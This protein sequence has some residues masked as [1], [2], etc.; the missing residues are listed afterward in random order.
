MAK[1]KSKSQKSLLKRLKAAFA[2]MEVCEKVN[3]SG[4]YRLKNKK[5]EVPLRSY[6]IQL[7][8]GQNVDAPLHLYPEWLINDD[9]E[10]ETSDHY[11]LFDPQRYFSEI[12]G[13]CR[14]DDGDKITLGDRHNSECDFVDCGDCDRGCRLSIRN[15]EGHLTFKDHNS[16]EGA[17]ISPLVDEKKINKLIKW[18]RGKLNRLKDIYGGPIKPLSDGDALKLIEQVNELQLEENSRP[19]NRK[20]LPG[21]VVKL[22]KGVTPIIVG[23]LHTKLDNLLVILSQN[24]FLESLEDGSAALI[25]L[26]DAVHSEEAGQYDKMKSSML[27]MDFIFKLKIRFPE[28][29]FYIRGNHDSFS[30]EIGKQGVPQGLL[31]EKTLL[32]QRGKAYHKAMQRL[33]DL[34][35]YVVHSKYFAACHAAPPT[36]SPD[37]EKLINITDHPDLIEE[38]YNNRLEKPNRPS[39]YNKRDIK[40]FRKCLGL[41]SDTPVIVGHTPLSLDETLWE[42]VNNI[43]NHYVVYGAGD[44]WIG[45]ITQVRGEI[46]PLRYPTEP[47][48]GY[49]DTLD[50]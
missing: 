2:G 30:E 26:G 5:I 9:G 32:K 50:D 44:E 18:R 29:V 1:S 15:E 16:T 40:K 31:W 20:D 25:L 8:L 10:G 35:P 37:Y 13:F 14:L 38:L 47:L 17:C 36:S 28:N 42:D 7:T 34:L 45:V 22:A 23:D 11:I 27:I 19:R 12:A 24:H 4:A 43:E 3:L 21:G 33:Y 41:E 48:M 46:V 39:G 49:I 6:P